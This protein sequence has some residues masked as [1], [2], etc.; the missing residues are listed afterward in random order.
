MSGD[1]FRLWLRLLINV[2]ALGA[3]VMVLSYCVALWLEERKLYL[4]IASWMTVAVI[5]VLLIR[6]AAVPEPPLLPLETLEVA[7][8]VA[9]GVLTLLLLAW[10]TALLQDRLH[11]VRLRRKYGIND[12]DDEE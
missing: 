4:A 2:F 7:S 10:L 3:V 11:A 1:E 9:N 8:L 6:I 12:K 5:P